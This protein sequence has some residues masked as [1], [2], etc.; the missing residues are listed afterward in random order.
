MELTVTTRKAEKKNDAK[1]LRREG[2]IPAIIYS[3]GKSGVT[4]GVSAVE[5]K[6]VLDRITPGALPAIVFTLMIEG[7]KIKAIVKGI[8]YHVTS[9]QVIHLD[10]IELHEKTKVTLNVPIVCQN[11]VDCAGVK[12]GGVLRQVVRHLKVRCLPK[13]IP[14]QFDVDV[15][16]LELHEKLMLYDVP[17]PDTVEPRMSLDTVAVAIGKR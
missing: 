8:Q 4:V 9:Y 3:E 12:L 5:F 16:D 15:K 2:M 14:T 6:K 10:F 11:V 7:K 17:L 1:K 13:D